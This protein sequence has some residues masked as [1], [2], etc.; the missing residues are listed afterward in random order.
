MW[1]PTMEESRRNALYEGW[2]RAVAR[3]LSTGAEAGA[4]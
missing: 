3:V 4:E 1:E 2:K